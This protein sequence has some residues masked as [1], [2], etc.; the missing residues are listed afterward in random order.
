MLERHG[1]EMQRRWHQQ[2]LQPIG[3]RDQVD[4]AWVD[5]CV[6]PSRLFRGQGA[7]V[8]SSSPYAVML[9]CACVSMV[10]GCHGLQ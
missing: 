3:Q 10:A 7:S 1:C 5:V 6:V 9:C 8:L 4:T 2:R